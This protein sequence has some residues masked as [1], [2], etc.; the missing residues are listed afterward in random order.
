[1]LLCLYN[2]LPPSSSP[3][4]P[5]T[6]LF[7]SLARID[8]PHIAHVAR[9]EIAASRGRAARLRAARRG[10]RGHS[11]TRGVHDAVTVARDD[12]ETPGADRKSTRLNSQSRFDL[13]CRLL[14]EKKKNGTRSRR[15]ST[16]TTRHNFPSPERW[17]DSRANQEIASQGRST[18]S[19]ARTHAQRSRNR[20]SRKR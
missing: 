4:F 6:T 9:D 1:Y 11:Q 7:R 8:L 10:Q 20:P 17:G 15:R 19:G 18:A 13:V 16:P 14:L 5:Y 3:L 2:V 12:L